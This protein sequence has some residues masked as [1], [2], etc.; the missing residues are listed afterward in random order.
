MCFIIL[1]DNILPHNATRH[2]T[3]H[4][5]INERS[6]GGSYHIMNNMPWQCQITI[7]ADWLDVSGSKMKLSSHKEL[8]WEMSQCFMSFSKSCCVL[9][10]DLCLIESH[11]SIWMYFDILD[12]F[13]YV[14]QTSVYLKYKFVFWHTLST[15][16]I[17]LKELH[18]ISLLVKKNILC[19]S[20]VMF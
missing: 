14:T 11:E 4:Y 9:Y 10:R 16:L 6:R 8:I 13:F 5:I 18:N 7:S 2:S 17:V 12:F 20:F 15:V 3:I 19:N 1:C